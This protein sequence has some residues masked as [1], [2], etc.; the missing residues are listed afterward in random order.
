MVGEGG[1]GIFGE[2][3][4]VYM[5]SNIHKGVFFVFPG[6]ALYTKFN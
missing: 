2:E 6:W 1:S 4:T 3:N 5:V